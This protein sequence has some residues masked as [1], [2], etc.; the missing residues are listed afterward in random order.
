M[1]ELIGSFAPIRIG[2]TRH[3]TVRTSQ[4]ARVVIRC[5]VRPPE[6]AEYRGCAECGEIYELNSGE[7]VSITPSFSTFRG[8]KGGLELYVEESG[9]RANRYEIV[10]ANFRDNEPPQQDLEL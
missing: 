8:R 1:A 5:F 7:R 10:L 2:E 6:P 4:V 9:G 3:F